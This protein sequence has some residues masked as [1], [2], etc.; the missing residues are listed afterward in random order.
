MTRFKYLGAIFS[1]EGSNPDVLS[2]T[3]KATAALTKMKPIWSNNNTSFGS[4]VNLMRSLVIRIFLYAFESCT[5]T[6]ELERR[7]QTMVTELLIQEP[8]HQ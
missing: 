8:C 2:R 6:A 1:D 5:L 7:T 4:K 3:A